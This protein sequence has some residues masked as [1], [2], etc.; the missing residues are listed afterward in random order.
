MRVEAKLETM[1]LELPA[2]FKPP[3]GIELPF[4]WVRARGNRAYNSG[5]VP[6]NPDGTLAAPLGKVGAEVSAETGTAPRGA[7]RSPTSQASSASSA[8]STA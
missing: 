2:P 7:S 1:W 5:H 6:L 8:T 3:P 4:A